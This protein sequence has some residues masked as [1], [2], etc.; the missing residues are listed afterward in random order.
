MYFTIRNKFPEVLKRLLR[1]LSLPFQEAMTIHHQYTFRVR[2]PF[3]RDIQS[4]PV[5]YGAFALSLPYI[6]AID[7]ALRMSNSPFLCSQLPL[8]WVMS[9]K[10]EVRQNIL[11]RVNNLYLKQIILQVQNCHLLLVYTNLICTYVMKLIT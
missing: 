11:S 3:I 1:I 4:R 6:T 7:S 5:Q 8:S 10:G 2:L 9:F